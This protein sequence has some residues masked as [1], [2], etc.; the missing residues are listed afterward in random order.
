MI[1]S[2]PEETLAEVNGE[3]AYAIETGRVLLTPQS[4]D[5][6]EDDPLASFSEW[7]SPDDAAAY[8]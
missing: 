3:L 6:A 1:T 7:D 2:S 4:T 5:P 8:A